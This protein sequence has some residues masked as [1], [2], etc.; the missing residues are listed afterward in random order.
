MADIVDSVPEFYTRTQRLPCPWEAKGK[1]MRYAMEFA[2][3]K[4]TQL[5]DG[6][7]ILMGK[8]D[9]VLVLP[10]PDKPFVNLTVESSSAKASDELLKM[11]TEKVNK[12]KTAD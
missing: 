3:D 12:W 5:I 7:K 1:V 4:E 2:K 11:I 10:D 6:V 8:G 9:W